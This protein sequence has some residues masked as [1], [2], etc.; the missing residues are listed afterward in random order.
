MA[1]NKKNKYA[2]SENKPKFITSLLL[3]AY[4]FVTVFTPNLQTLDSNG[5]KFLAFAILNVI[6]FF[7]LYNIKEIR[8]N[9]KNLFGFFD[10][11]IGVA[12][13]LLMILSLLSFMK[14]INISESILHFAKIF[15]SFMAVW[16][17]STIIR[18]DR[19]TIK[20]LAIAMSILLFWDIAQVSGEII[21]FVKGKISIDEIK[22]TYSN[23]NILSSAIFVKIPFALWLLI[24]NKKIVKYLGLVALM[25]SVLAIFFLTTRAFLVG[26]I[27]LVVLLLIYFLTKIK[28]VGSKTLLKVGVVLFFALILLGVFYKYQN[29]IY[30]Q[31]G[32]RHTIEQRLKSIQNTKTYKKR[33]KAWEYSLK[34]IKQDPILGVGLGNWKLRVLEYENREKSDYIYQ[35]KVHN[36]F[37]E[38]T[39]EVGI[40]GG[41]FFVSI[42]LFILW[43]FSVLLFNKKDEEAEKLFFLPTFGIVAYSVD[44]FFNFPQDRPE[45]QSLFALYV[46]IAIGLALIFFKEDSFIVKLFKKINKKQLQIVALVIM[47]LFS[48]GSVYI[49]FGNFQSLK[50]QRIIREELNFG[51]L[52]SS[53]NRFIRTF[54]SIPNVN[55]Y[56]EPIAVQKARYL[57]KEG[58]HKEAQNILR[59]DNSNPFDGRKE[60]FMAKSFYVQKQYDSVIYYA[61][62]CHKIKPLFYANNTY[63]VSSYELTGQFDKA[64][65]LWKSYLKREKNNP[66]PWMFLAKILKMQNREEEAKRVIEEAFKYHPNNKK[67]IALR[68][69]L[70][71]AFVLQSGLIS[72][73]NLDAYGSKSGANVG[74]YNAHNRANQQWKI[75]SVTKDVF[76]FSPMNAKG[77][78]LDVK[79]GVY[80]KGTNVL[81]W[82]DKGT[83][84]QK[85]KIISLGN[86]Y[87]RIYPMEA[88]QFSLS[89]IGGNKKMLNVVLLPTSNTSKAQM[90]KLERVRE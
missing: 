38:I 58:K 10:N 88:P 20:L 81:L 24:F 74:V 72:K 42:F 28:R 84:N 43:Y 59:Q 62:K 23:R 68:G 57:I 2:N 71:G 3:V 77:S 32:K 35:Y 50:L 11:K 63:L 33:L 86:G 30:S 15:T 6:A 26:I 37:L 5:P 17:I 67:I 44:A 21:S 18:Y 16:L 70:S 60:F 34:L 83:L 53:S 85:W 4:G 75:I 1:N 79:G 76:K 66:Q 52:N 54:P 13:S 90:W 73:I 51:H 55:A 45:I 27:L 40:F 48:L 78:V 9:K 82:E 25:I 7:I 14:S 56:A 61:E 22:E 31:R 64:I 29:K 36:D 69:M 80:A 8:T 89:V 65:G 41:I 47:V 12:Y 19:N 49:L 46:G 87:Y 39:S